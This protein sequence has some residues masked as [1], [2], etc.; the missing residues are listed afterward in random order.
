MAVV[1]LRPKILERLAEAVAAA[2]GAEV[3]AKV[4]YH[5]PEEFVSELR[6]LAQLA[7]TKPKPPPKPNTEIIGDYEVESEF[8][9]LTHEDQKQREEAAIRVVADV[10]RRSK[11][12][13]NRIATCMW[14][15]TFISSLLNRTSSCSVTTCDERRVSQFHRHYAF[16]PGEKL[17]GRRGLANILPNLSSLHSRLRY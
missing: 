16:A 2:L 8:P 1:S 10:M 3:A 15:R 14:N 11:R 7:A 9:T 5:T 6:R 17:A 12:N 13:S 4:S